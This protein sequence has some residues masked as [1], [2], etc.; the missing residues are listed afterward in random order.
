MTRRDLTRRDAATRLWTAVSASHSA[1]LVMQSHQR[2][3]RRKQA[4][5]AADRL[6]SFARSM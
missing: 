2:I 5:V 1:G 3:S 6:R 4:I